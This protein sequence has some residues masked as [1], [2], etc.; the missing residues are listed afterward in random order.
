MAD[1]I[2]LDVAGQPVRIT[3]PEKVFFLGLSKLDLVESYLAVG[4]G[5]HV[6]CRERPTM[7]KRHPSGVDGDFFYQK[8]VPSERPPWI[9]TATVT[10]PSGRSATFLAPVDTA[11]I[12]WAVNLGCMELHPWPVR[13]SDLD[14]P[15][16][17]RIDVDPT[18]EVPFADVRTVTLLV[19]EVLAAR[20]GGDL[21]QARYAR[22]RPY[23]GRRSTTRWAGSTR[24][25]SRRVM[26]SKARE[27]NEKR[28]RQ[29]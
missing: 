5:A 19:G 13:R 23:R 21:R 16:E 15:D 2:E 3:N 1:S 27:P 7:L 28:G 18:P 17:L 11:H 10:F 22:Q 4:G 6:G 29:S 12:A 26:P 24:C 14:R 25:S 20:A 8:R 9:Q